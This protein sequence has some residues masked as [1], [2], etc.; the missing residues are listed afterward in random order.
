M[1]LLDRDY[2]NPDYPKHK[3]HCTCY[4][5]ESRRRCPDKW[6]I[7]E[8]NGTKTKQSFWDKMKRK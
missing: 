2:M 8:V 3:P 7:N 6:M 1:G 4:E 5:C